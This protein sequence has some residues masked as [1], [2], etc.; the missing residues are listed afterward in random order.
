MD[1]ERLESLLI[2]YIDGNLDED[3]RAEVENELR[4]SEEAMRLYAQLKNLLSTIN[5]VA[6]HDPP[7]KLQSSFAKQLADEIGNSEKSRSLFFQPYIYRI[8]AALALVMAGVAV[9]YWINRRTGHDQELAS[10]RKEMQETKE[11]MISMM[12]N[13]QSASQRMQGVNVAYSITNADDEIIKV[14]AE[15]MNNDPNTN[16]RLAAMEALTRFIDQEKVRKIM[17]SSLSHQHDPVIQIP[18]IQLLVKIKEQGVIQDLKNI[19]NDEKTLPVVKDE[20][21]LGIMSLS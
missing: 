9:G 16:V 19:I 3:S 10:L 2:D 17:I 5:K 7:S 21:H 15:A 11:L 6:P 8:A 4:E 18:L 14:L 13:S 12:N 1:K 20:A